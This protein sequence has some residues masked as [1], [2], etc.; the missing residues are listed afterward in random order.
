ML[1]S[2]CL[3]HAITELLFT[4]RYKVK[5]QIVKSPVFGLILKKTRNI[6]IFNKNF[7]ILPTSFKLFGNNLNKEEPSIE[8]IGIITQTIDKYFNEQHNLNL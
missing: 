7:I 8:N 5:L 2:R 3:L 6:P 4:E 1:Y